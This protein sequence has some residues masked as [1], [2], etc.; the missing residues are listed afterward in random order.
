MDPLRRY[1]HADTE[2][3]V[4]EK[5]AAIAQSEASVAEK[6]EI[7]EASEQ[8]EFRARSVVSSFS[9]IFKRKMQKLPLF[10]VHFTKK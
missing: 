10:S 2:L 4:A 9:A 1:M 3:G 8:K 6:Q 5:Q 7:F